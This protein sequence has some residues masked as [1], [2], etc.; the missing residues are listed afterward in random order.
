MD[1]A[2]EGSGKI[3]VAVEAF[4]G[5]MDLLVSLIRQ[6]K[7]DIYDIPIA[8]IADRFVES[9]AQ[10]EK[11]D[12]EITSEFLVLAAQL[13]FLKSRELLPRPQK[14]AEELAEEEI[15][16][17]DLVDRVIVYRAYKD[18]ADFLRARDR[19]GGTPFFRDIDVNE[20][21]TALPRPDPLEGVTLAALG[22][23]FAGV[24]ARAED[25]E[26]TD[27]LDAEEIQIDMMVRGIMRRVLLHPEGLLFSR[28]VSRRSR[29]ELIIAFIA[30]LELLRGGR[31][32]AFQGEGAEE[33]FIAPA[34]KARDFADSESAL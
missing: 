31:L 23:I 28:L 17:Q 4:R 18:A 29:L 2:D 24:L 10:M 1:Y 14:S 22:R 7:V 32:R 27:T 9:L 15:L 16:K 34:D 20:L 12:L 8:L 3:Y 6:H 25:E 26:R 19:E 21:L 30:V 5:P 13:L 11:L 33:I